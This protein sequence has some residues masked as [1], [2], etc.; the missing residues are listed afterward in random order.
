M[1]SS[2]G[3]SSVDHNRLRGCVPRLPRTATPLIVTEIPSPKGAQFSFGSD[4]GGPP[5]LSPDGRT[6]AFVASDA[7]GKNALWVRH[8]DSTFA[9]TLAET[10]GT[11]RPFWSADSR[12]IGFFADGKLKT[13]E[14]A[15][16]PVVTL[17]DAPSGVGG[18][19]SR[20]GIILFHASAHG[21]LYQIAASGGTPI[22][23]TTVDATKF[24]YHFWPQFL[25]DDKHFL[26]LAVGSDPASTGVYFASLDGKENRLVLRTSNRAV[27]SLGYLLYSR[28]TELTAQAFDPDR[29]QLKGEASQL[30]QGVRV[31]PIYSGGFFAVSENGL[32][33]YQPGEESTGSKLTWFDRS[34]KRL[35][36]IGGAAA[37]YDVQLSPDG[38]RLA[39]AMGDPNSE[40]WVDD[41]ARGV[42][43]RL[44]FD[45]ATD[46]GMPVWSPDGAWILFATLRGGKAQLGIYQKASNGAGAEELLLPSDSADTEA[47]ATDWSR[48]GRFVIY[49]SGVNRTRGDIRILPLVG[50]RKPHLFLQAPAGA[51][52]G[53]FSPDGRWIAYISNESGRDEVY[54]V[55]FDA[56]KALKTGPG[57][58]NTGPIDRWQVSTDGGTFPRW[59]TDG[60]Q[61]F[62]LSAGGKMMAAE[63]NGRGANLEV[64][65]PRALFSAPTTVSMSP[66]DVSPDG[67]R[68]LF[69]APGEQENPALRLVVNWTAILKKR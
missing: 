63:V 19:W 8:L 51:Y 3:S 58:A 16:G 44:T 29:G 39:S 59:R 60:K 43:M 46:K 52:G 18:S 20:Q 50:D 62:Y 69:I 65:T 23:V 64:G 56:T 33:A 40:I 26:Y 11:S 22:P 41:L 54:V 31:E 47:I 24:S 36:A 37:Y 13:V 4:A 6:L 67:T 32:L 55:P 38:G 57:P 53:R 21:G 49:S 28:G 9:Q 42:R 45:P 34:G 7:S 15:T 1:G 68:F 10:E 66:Y 5:A 61:I 35:G 14:A 17:C 2:G 48:D 12:S 30:V 27:Y 25:P